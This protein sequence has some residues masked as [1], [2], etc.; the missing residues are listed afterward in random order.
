MEKVGNAS[1][2]TTISSH[3]PPIHSFNIASPEIAKHYCFAI[4]YCFWWMV[5]NMILES[6]HSEEI[7]KLLCCVAEGRKRS[8]KKTRLAFTSCLQLLVWWRLRFK[9][10]SVVAFHRCH[11][12]F[13]HWD[14]DDLRQQFIQMSVILQYF[15]R[16]S[17][18][19]QLGARRSAVSVPSDWGE[20][21]V[22]LQTIRLV[23]IQRTISNWNINKEL[24][25]G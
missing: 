10:E 18:A 20:T 11:W 24:L 4:L 21:A 2:Y 15:G 13:T 22:G 14:T 1:H 3:K 17:E 9:R 5:L 6:D 23:R 12:R 25:D 7:Q 8:R 16:L 19:G